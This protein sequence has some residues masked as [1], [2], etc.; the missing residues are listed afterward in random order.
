[1]SEVLRCPV[2]KADD[3]QGP[4]CRRCKADL[5][6]LVALEKQRRRALD[7]AYACAVSGQWRRCLAIALGIDALRRD[8][9]SRRLVA[10]AQLL[11]RDFA[12][13]WQEHAD[14]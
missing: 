1:M 13:A 10:A 2:C 3:P 14:R 9:E 5:S 12:V 4:R 7:A 6:A 8:E 11:N